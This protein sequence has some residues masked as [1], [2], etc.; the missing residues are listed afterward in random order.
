MSVDVMLQHT[1]QPY[2][3]TS[4]NAMEMRGILCAAVTVYCGL[5]FLTGD[6][7][8][9]QKYFFFVMIILVNVIFVY[10][11]ATQLAGVPMPVVGGTCVA[12]SSSFAFSY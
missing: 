8:Q 4:L 7:A 3:Y 5:Y 9:Y 11:F 1:L 2:S 10:Y 12:Q 6:L